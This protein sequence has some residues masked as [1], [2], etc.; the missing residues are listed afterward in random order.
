MTKLRDRIDAEFENIDASLQHLPDAGR[1]PLLSDLELA[2]V[3]ALLNSSYNGVEN[4]LK[5]IPIPAYMLDVEPQRLD[6]L[7]RDLAATVS[8]VSRVCIWSKSVE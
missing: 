4:I 2:G 3:A 6:P 1:L 7:V 8:N 5:Q